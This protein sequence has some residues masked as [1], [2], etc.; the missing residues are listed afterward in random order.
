MHGLHEFNLTGSILKIRYLRQPNPAQGP[1]LGI[2]VCAP[3][4]V[5]WFFY[6]LMVMKNRTERESE[7]RV[8]K[9]STFIGHLYGHWFNDSIKEK[10]GRLMDG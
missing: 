2:G 7:S 1:L 10:H 8:M 5:A 9:V 6:W 4:L 3:L